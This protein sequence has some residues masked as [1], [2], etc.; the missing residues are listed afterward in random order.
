MKIMDKP[1]E[2][3][4][5]V[6]DQPANL[7]VLSQTLENIG[8]KQL[9]AKNG[10]SALA[11]AQKVRPDLILLDIMMPGI[12]GFEVCRRLKTNPDTQKIP[13]IFL[14][15]LDE[16]SDKVRGLQLGAVDYVAKP[17][18]PEE[19]IARVNTHLMIHRLSTEVQ[20]QRD[21][22]EHELQVVSQLQ[23]NLLPERLPEIDGL[24]LAVHYETSR[25]TGGD[26]YDVVVLPDGRLTILVADAEGH[27]APATV[28]MAMTCALFRSC[29]TCLGEPDQMLAYIN[30]NLC[31]VNRGSFV[32]AIY[33]VYDIPSRTLKMARAGNPLPILYKPS[34]RTATE[35]SCE[36]VLIMG[37]EAYAEVPVTEVTLL[38]GDQLLFYTDGV[39]DR[40]NE[41]KKFYGT[42]RLLQQFGTADS[43]DPAAI[44]KGITDD[45]SRFAGHRPA[46]DDQAMLI[47]VVE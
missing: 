11:I 23:R 29:S 10:E 46:D 26:Y 30:E 6:D 20:M 12:D 4:L 24:K 44:L 31:K 16:T 43:D 45:L 42:E 32:T 17:F 47:L 28:M 7:Q 38:P 25:Y 14:S 33:A 40:L 21:E 8:C 19:V 27:S 5:L 13:V 22:L 9:F 39:T 36:G 34:E 15:A 3:I 35:L 41:D 37:L 1:Q 18:Q 2:S